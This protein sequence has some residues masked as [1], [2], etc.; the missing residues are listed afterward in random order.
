MK[1]LPE[2]DRPAYLMTSRQRPAPVENPQRV[3][4]DEEGVSGPG[5]GDEIM[6]EVEEQEDGYSEPL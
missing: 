5:E 1:A 2:A 6:D 4:E 3:L